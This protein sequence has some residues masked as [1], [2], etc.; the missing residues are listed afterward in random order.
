MTEVGSDTLEPLSQESFQDLWNMVAIPDQVTGDSEWLDNA[1]ITDDMDTLQH[2][3]I[4]SSNELFSGVPFEAINPVPSGLASND[5]GAPSASVVPSTKDYPGD[6]GFKLR[7]QQSSTAKSVTCTYSP[8]LNKLFCQ[9]AKTCPVQ[10]TVDKPPPPGTLI[11]ATA[12]YKKSEHVADVVRRCPHHEQTTENN[13]GPA[14]R[15]HLI[16]VEGNHQA[17]YWDDLNTKRQS[18]TVPYETPQLGSDCIT[19]LYNYMCNSSCMGGMNRRPI[20]TIVTLET[21]EG[22]LIGRRCFEVRVCACPG[23][24]RKS[25]EENCHKQQENA[26]C[27]SSSGT[28]RNI[29]DVTQPISHPESSKKNKSSSDEEV[30]ILQVRGRERYEMLKRINDSLELKDVIPHTDLEKYRQKLN[31]KNSNRKDRE[32]VEPKEGKKLLVKEEK[33]DSD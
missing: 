2:G 18:V 33:S 8:V 12:V 5:T 27:K 4:S 11:R 9:L 7:F 21:K 1:L 24:D 32:K 6:V 28:K 3:Y 20:I 29:K 14:P 16:R 23:R 15:S 10:M 13:E 26:S 30:F 17:E 25:E 19:V 22:L 31:L